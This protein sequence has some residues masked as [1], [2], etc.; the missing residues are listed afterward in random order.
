MEK[1][2]L[3]MIAEKQH[4][5]LIEEKWTQFMAMLQS[6]GKTTDNFSTKD[7]FKM[8]YEIGLEDGK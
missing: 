1:Q 2:T 5:E 3:D 6:W 8:A 7:I 4:E